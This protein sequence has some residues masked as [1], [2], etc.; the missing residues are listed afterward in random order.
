MPRRVANCVGRLFGADAAATTPLATS[1][2]AT[3]ADLRSCGG[4]AAAA[5]AACAAGA[6]AALISASC[7]ATRADLSGCGGCA[8]AAAA[9]GATGAFCCTTVRSLPGQAR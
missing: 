8:A 4:C 3:R 2:A 1:C 9:A 5:A 6:A 7:A